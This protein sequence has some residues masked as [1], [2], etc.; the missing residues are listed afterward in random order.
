VQHRVNGDNFHVG[1]DDIQ[2]LQNR[3]HF[4]VH[5]K[6]M[7]TSRKY[8]PKSNFIEFGSTGASEE[9]GR[10]LVLRDVLIRLFFIL[11]LEGFSCIIAQK[12]QNNARG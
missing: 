4:T 7:T 2:P 12:M 3:N 9:M 1:N 10:I 11:A 8:V 6:F 5:L